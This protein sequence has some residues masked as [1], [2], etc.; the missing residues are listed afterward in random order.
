MMPVPAR[1]IEDLSLKAFVH[2]HCAFE[3]QEDAACD[4]YGVTPGKSMAHD[5]KY[6]VFQSDYPGYAGQKEEACHK[7]KS[8]PD[9][10]GMPALLLGQ[11]GCQNGDEDNVVEA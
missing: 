10:K 3:Q 1:R 11:C 9:N 7:G 4:E 5:G 2:L 6:R 8:Q